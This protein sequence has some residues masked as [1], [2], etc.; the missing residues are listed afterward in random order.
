MLQQYIEA[1]DVLCKS[2]IMTPVK[3][4]TNYLSD[5]GLSDIVLHMV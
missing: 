4:N 2:I 5:I 3:Q 1:N